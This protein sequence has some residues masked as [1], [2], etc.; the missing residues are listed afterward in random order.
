[1]IF[2]TL[3]YT[4]IFNWTTAAHVISGLL[5]L[6]TAIAIIGLIIRIV[7]RGSPRDDSHQ[8]GSIAYVDRPQKSE[9]ESTED[10]DTLDNAVSSQEQGWTI[11]CVIPSSHCAAVTS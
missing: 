2:Y 4:G 7:K 5:V 10:Y 9:D 11:Y 8:L 1:M 6:I 3:F